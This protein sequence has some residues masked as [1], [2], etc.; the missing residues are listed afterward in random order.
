MRSKVSLIL[1][2]AGL[3]IGS[4]ASAATLRVERDGTGDFTTI[5]DAID[6]ASPGDLVLL[7]PGRYTEVTTIVS[8]STTFWIH[9]YVTVDDLT[10]RGLDRDAVV[11]GPE[12]GP[13]A[14]F[15]A[16]FYWW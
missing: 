16:G 8:G 2:F 7:G 11:I 4:V 13:P 12:S 10:F 3:T 6:A 1:L 15:E 9:A 14:F 5:Q